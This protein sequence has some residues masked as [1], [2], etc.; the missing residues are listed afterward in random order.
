MLSK[1]PRWRPPAPARH[2]RIEEASPVQVQLQ[3][4]LVDEFAHGA[5]VGQWQHL[6][7]MGI[8]QADE[9][10]LDEWG[11]SGSDGPRT[12]SMARVPSACMG[13]GLQATEPSARQSPG[14]RS[15]NVGAAPSTALPTLA[16]TVMASRVGHGAG[17]VEQGRPLPRKLAPRRSSALML[18]FPIGFVSH[19]ACS[20]LWR[21]ASVGWSRYHSCKSI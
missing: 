17:G 6:A 16:V 20:M 3:P 12:S 2:H 18:I 19:P 13:D 9:V 7:V 14:P 1:A 11:S 21:M 15:D 4:L 10:R 5:W 8:F